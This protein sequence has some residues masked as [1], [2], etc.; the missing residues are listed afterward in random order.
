[1][2]FVGSGS[3]RGKQELKADEGQGRTKLEVSLLCL[4]ECEGVSIKDLLEEEIDQKCYTQGSGP[5]CPLAW[6]QHRSAT[7][8]SPLP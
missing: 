7:G 2:V 1:M 6:R 8:E 3:S 4:R 5:L